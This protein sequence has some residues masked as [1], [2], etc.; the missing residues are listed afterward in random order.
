MARPPRWRR[1]PFRAELQALYA[2]TDALLEGWACACTEGLS[3]TAPCCDFGVLGR[4][5]YPT[6]VELEE[7]R[8]ALLAS[9]FS[10][11]DHRRLPLAGHALCPLL[12]AAG[13]CLVY[14]SRPFGCRTFFCPEARGPCGSPQRVPR[15]AINA[16][17]RRIADLSARFAPKDPA[18]R[19]LRRALVRLT[20][21]KPSKP[22][23]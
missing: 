7:V 20:S 4:E 6:A 23:R 18:P 11:R 3:H 14:A 2:E 13:R 21:E 15:E 12:S 22:P 16:V 8:H 17:G 10:A 1:S 5:P 19:P 9:G